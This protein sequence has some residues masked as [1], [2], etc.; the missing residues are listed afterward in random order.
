MDEFDDMI[1]GDVFRYGL[2]AEGNIDTLEPVALEDNAEFAAKESVVYGEVSVADKTSTGKRYIKVGE[3]TY[4]FADAEGATFVKIDAD[5]VD[6]IGD[7]AIDVTSISGI[8][9]STSRTMYEVLLLLDEDELIVD[10][11][12][13]VS[14]K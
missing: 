14:A 7:A 8:K 9:A 2:D 12:V 1:P 3:K 6:T 10:A 4:R 11:I 13:Y 5:K